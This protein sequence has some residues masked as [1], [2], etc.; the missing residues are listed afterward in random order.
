MEVKGI[1]RASEEKLGRASEKIILMSDFKA[2]VVEVVS[3]VPRGKVV[4]YGQVAA[5]VGLPR[6]AREVGWVLSVLGEVTPWWRVIN[7][8]GY[9]S[10]RGNINADK[11]RQ[12]GLLILE[13]IPVDE[14]FR[15]PIEEYRF[16]PT[17]TELRKFQ[18]E[19]EYIRTLIEKYGI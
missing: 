6:A 3:S 4:S 13:G 17:E 16:K 5:Y 8:K 11:E 9:I 2:K 1:K 19:G 15:L 14:E 12:A 10:I 7:N 18:L